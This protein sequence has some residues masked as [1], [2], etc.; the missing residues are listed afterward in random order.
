MI[1]P[2]LTATSHTILLERDCRKVK[3]AWWD[4]DMEMCAIAVLSRNLAYAAE[5]VYDV[6]NA[7]NRK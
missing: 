2:I 1:C 3:C 4:K 7:I 5:N 6:A